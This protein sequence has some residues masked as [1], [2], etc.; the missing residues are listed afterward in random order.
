MPKSNLSGG[1]NKK[2]KL[3]LAQMSVKERDSIKDVHE[4]LKVAKAQEDKNRSRK[5]TQADIN[6]ENKEKRGNIKPVTVKV[7][8]NAQPKSSGLTQGTKMTREEVQEKYFKRTLDP[9]RDQLSILVEN[10]NQM[11]FQQRE[12]GIQSRAAL[13]AERSLNKRGQE[14][15]YQTMEPFQADLKSRRDINRE[16]S[17]VMNFLSDYT[18]SLEGGLVE[19][20]TMSHLFGGQWRKQGYAGYDE[21]S[22]SKE[23]ADMVFSIYHRVLEQ[24]GGWQRVIGYF[25]AINPG[26]VDY[27]SENLINAIY[28]MVQN[29]DTIYTPEGMDVEGAILGRA[30]D[31]VNNM[32][33]NYMKLAVLQ[34]SGNDY[35]SI[36]DREEAEQ[37]RKV[38][39]WSLARE[40][41]KED[42]KNG[43]N[44][45]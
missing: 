35:G 14:H 13:E 40:K 28:D 9:L 5:L 21:K 39:E 7:R 6:R 25:R 34:R 24:G 19:Q 43:R 29:K 41:Y 23:D 3:K 33:D 36:E 27:G 31:I 16:F 45:W 4:R 38:Y 20:Q 12:L 42:I 8:P 30:M 18:A 15:F 17:R 2:T 37:R 44:L 22:V 10:A 26:V 11:Y 1:K 32:I